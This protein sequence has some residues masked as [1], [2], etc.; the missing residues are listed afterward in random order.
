MTLQCNRTWFIA[1]SFFQ[2]EDRP[3]NKWAL[4]HIGSSSLLK[5]CC[6]RSLFTT[7]LEMLMTHTLA[8]SKDKIVAFTQILLNVRGKWSCW[9]ERLWAFLRLSVHCQLS[10]VFFGFDL[11][12][13]WILAATLFIFT[14]IPI[15]HEWAEMQGV[16]LCMRK[17]GENII[18]INVVKYPHP[19]PH[20]KINMHTADFT[21]VLHFNLF[22]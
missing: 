3:I 11:L 15:S 16:C 10:C 13:L 12:Y 14:F 19:G 22:Q 5:P 6:S 17:K 9:A 2:G 8:V 18:N 7:T 21:S 20:T 4:I 1:S